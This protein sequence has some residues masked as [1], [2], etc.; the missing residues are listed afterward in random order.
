VEHEERS[1]SDLAHCQVT[2]VAES[3]VPLAFFGRRPYVLF[4]VNVGDC[5]ETVVQDHPRRLDNATHDSICY[6]AAV[7]PRRWF[8]T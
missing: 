5:R 4:R 3:I 1:V 6:N 2:V 7:P 8:L